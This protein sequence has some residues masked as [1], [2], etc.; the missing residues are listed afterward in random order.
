MEATRNRRRAG[1]TLIELLVVIAIVAIL[2]ALLLPALEAAR[3]SARRAVCTNNHRQLYV[4]I[5]F[6][7]NDWNDRLPYW[8]ASYL[9]YDKDMVYWLADN[10]PHR[11]FW[12][13]YCNINMPRNAQGVYTR[14]GRPY[15]SE[16]TKIMWCPSATPTRE[17]TTYNCAGDINYR[18]PAFGNRAEAE[19]YGTTIDPNC[20]GTTRLTFVGADGVGHNGTTAPF[21]LIVDEYC[22]KL[23]EIWSGNNHAFAGGNVT[24]GN[25]STAWVP[26][27]DWIGNSLHWGGDGQK[28]LAG[29]KGYWFLLWVDSGSTFRVRNPVNAWDMFSDIHY[30]RMFGFDKLP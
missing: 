2:A 6:Y 1:F 4:A 25:G 27:E 24:T 10:A 29:P 19:G 20:R 7:S 12:G 5:T 23:G 8:R 11:V 30:G 3:E 18:F 22:N 28:P 26:K 13:D 9:R 17:S 21:A 15:Y 14:L 16:R